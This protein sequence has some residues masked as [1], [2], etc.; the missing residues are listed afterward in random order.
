[1]SK[2]HWAIGHL[3]NRK[4]RPKTCL[5][6]TR[7]ALG[8]EGLR[9]PWRPWPFNTALGCLKALKRNPAKYGW[10]QVGPSVGLPFA[11]YDAILVFFDR[12]GELK[13]GRIAGH[14]G[15]LD[16][17]TNTLFSNRDDRLNS[18]WLERIAAAYV[19]LG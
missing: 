15:I 18:W 14:V 13:D 5:G 3:K 17:D 7:W 6:D 9:L 19:P 2:L 11:E 10:R 8:K 12:C 16:V 4:N 1:M